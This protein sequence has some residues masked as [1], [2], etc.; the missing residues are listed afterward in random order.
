MSAGARQPSLVGAAA[1]PA[2]GLDPAPLLLG[3][4]TLLS[5]VIALTGGAIG[6]QSGG[7]FVAV[8]A[9][10]GLCAALAMSTGALGARRGPAWLGV[11][12]L[13]LFAAWCALSIVWSVAPADSWLAANRA[14]AYAVIA[15]VALLAGS[16]VRGAQAGVALALSAVGVVV[17][18]CALAF[19]VV[20]GI[21]VGPI[22]FESGARFARIS[23]PLEYWNALALLAVMAAAPCIWFASS[24]EAARG[25]RIAA[26]LSLALLLLTAALA[27]SRSAVIGYVV[28][29]AIMVGAGPRRLTRLAVGVGALFGI[30]PAL[31]VAFARHDLSSGGVSLAERIDDGL[32]LG[33]VIALCLIAL[34]LVADTMMRLERRGAFTRERALRIWR[35]L[36]F[37]AAAAVVAGLLAI[38]V[39]GRGLPGEVSHQ[40]EQ[41]KTPSAVDSNSPERFI[42]VNS[43][44]RYVWW[45]EASEAFADRPLEGHGAGTF[46]TLHVLYREERAPVRSSHS[47]PLML[48]SE[49]G[50]V[51]FALGMSA[52]AALG[53]A[54]VGRIR[55]SEGTERSA[56]LALAAAYAAWLVESMTDWHWEIPAVTVPALL[57]ACVAAAPRPGRRPAF[58][59]RRP[60]LAA[61]AAAL[62]AVGLALSGYLPVMA[63][64]H[65]LQALAA[66][67][68]QDDEGLIEATADAET[69]HRL[70]PL[71]AEPLLILASLAQRRGEPREALAYLRQAA[72]IEPDNGVVQR[73]LFETYVTT[74][75]LAEG[76]DALAAWAETDPLSSRFYGNL[77]P[78]QSFVIRY[79]AGASPTA[80][81][82]PPD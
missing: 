59:P 24:R 25:A 27:Y 3:S 43:S 10:I 55:A 63:D 82:T 61:G 80:A 45:K 21:E 5:A 56:R 71:A 73:R 22:N 34:A 32:L 39:L 29:L 8:S 50:I 49:T 79:P 68:S 17:A 1:G 20:P 51:G 37:G 15:A 54:V 7:R 48:L 70:N 78:S 66:A 69:A 64:Q 9:A 36:G 4:L 60:V 47:L 53:L 19:K 28:L 75:Y 77:T 46:P 52:L 14:L 2:R 26:V 12:L 62:A 11:G 31:V 72:R 40:I 42:S 41:F 35:I 30:G 44:S 57:A 13:A 74:G 65:Q 58:G 33:A 67:S 23:D 76:A 18:L 6:L 16:A 81:A 38:S